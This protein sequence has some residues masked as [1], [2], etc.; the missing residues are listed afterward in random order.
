MRDGATLDL[1][2]DL[3]DGL[4]AQEMLAQGAWL[5]RGYCKDMGAALLDAVE[6]IVAVAPFR[7]MYTAGGYLM[8][9][10]MTNCGVAG[11]ISDQHGYRYATHDPETG[12]RWPAIP[13]IFMELAQQ[14][15]AHAG[16]D[17]FQPDACL[18]NCYLPGSRLSLHQDKNERNFGAPIVSVSLGLPAVFLFGG[19][20]RSDR[21]RRYRLQHGDVAVWGGPSR[22]AYHGIA[23][24][25]DGLHPLAGRRRINLTFREAR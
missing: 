14:A 2:D 20:Q 11:W 3:P 25:A 18:V 5:L 21:P 6:Q 1:F 23:P 13:D 19:Q 12:R 15:A 10:P 8:S 9:V 16:Y 17:H 22:M 24:L 4:P 7:S